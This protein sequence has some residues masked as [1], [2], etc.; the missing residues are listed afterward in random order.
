MTETS[1]LKQEEKV[2]NYHGMFSFPKGT[3]TLTYDTLTWKND[4]SE[5]MVSISEI[6]NTIV[7]IKNNISMLIISTNSNE[8]EIELGW[9]VQVAHTNTFG[10]FGGGFGGGMSATSQ[11]N[12]ST[13]SWQQIIEDLRLGKLKKPEAEKK[14]PMCA[15]LIKLEAKICRF[16]NYKFE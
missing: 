14:C 5:Q 1:N 2:Y 10:A 4:E 6:K 12:P 15:E 9:K 3:L 8:N 16:C 13:L 7:K 11:L